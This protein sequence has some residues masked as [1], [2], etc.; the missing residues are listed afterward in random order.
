[1]DKRTTEYT[2]LTDHHVSL[3][4]EKDE[5]V[6]KIIE[7][8]SKKSGKTIENTTYQILRYF[9]IYLSLRSEFGEVKII[10]SD[11]HIFLEFFSTF[12]AGFAFRSLH[13]ELIN[14]SEFETKKLISNI[15]KH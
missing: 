10:L 4:K 3:I 7:E 12:M 2:N 6:E 5:I 11:D 14:D 13:Q 15:T 9:D 8:I 1:M